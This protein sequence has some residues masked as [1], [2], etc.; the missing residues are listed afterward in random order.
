MTDGIV[1][2]AA[3]AVANV[4]TRVGFDVWW[5]YTHA[6]HRKYTQRNVYVAV[7]AAFHTH[8]HM[9]TRKQIFLF[10]IHR[11]TENRQHRT[12]DGKR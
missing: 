6:M 12:T 5:Q 10:L 2:A 9:H 11:L 8:T 4:S 1:L 3:N 7:I